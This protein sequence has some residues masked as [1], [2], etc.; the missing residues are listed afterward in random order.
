MLL[1]NMQ[2]AVIPKLYNGR[3][4]EF[5]ASHQI[6]LLNGNASFYFADTVNTDNI[7]AEYS[8]MKV[9]SK[10]RVLDFIASLNNLNSTADSIAINQASNIDFIVHLKTKLALLD[11][12]NESNEQVTELN[13]ND[14]ELLIAVRNHEAIMLMPSNNYFK[15]YYSC[16][17]SYPKCYTTN[18]DLKTYFDEA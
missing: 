6:K 7:R 9:L 2:T 18:T 3:Q 14:I 13:L 1:T 11:V 5:I 8:E 12:Y 4:G 15:V 17:S 16:R 10:Q